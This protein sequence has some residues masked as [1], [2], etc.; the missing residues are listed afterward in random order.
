[1]LIYL[2]VRFTKGIINIANKVALRVD[3]AEDLQKVCNETALEI[4]KDFGIIHTVS[5]Y[6]FGYT[7]NIN[8]NILNWQP[9][10]KIKKELV[11]FELANSTFNT[12]VQY[13]EEKVPAMSGNIDNLKLFWNKLSKSSSFA[14]KAHKELKKINS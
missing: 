5:N 2:S 7:E 11:D 9:C 1:M 14:H 12:V 6:E 8:S 10:V 13:F 4:L 3:K